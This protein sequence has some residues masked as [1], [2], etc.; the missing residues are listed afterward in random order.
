MMIMIIMV[1]MKTVWMDTMIMMTISAVSEIHIM[2]V[3]IYIGTKTTSTII[4]RYYY[5]VL[6]FLV[7]EIHTQVMETS[8]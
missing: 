5:I 8:T 6:V 2:Y 3:N 4:C 1:L 7:M